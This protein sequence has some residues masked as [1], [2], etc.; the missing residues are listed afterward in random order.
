MLYAIGVLVFALGLLASIALHEV[1][2]M[3]P[4][5]R[6]GVKVTQY[7]VGFGPTLWSKRKGD[8]EYGV[9][10]I[11][12]G[13][14][15]RMIGMVPPRADGKRSR[16][17]RRMAS[18]VED[19]RNASRSEVLA[20]EDEPR[21]FYRLT[22][23]KKMIVMVGGPSMN[24]V[25]Y[26]VLTLILI[27]VVGTRHD[28]ATKTVATIET[29]VVPASASTA[30]APSSTC[31]AN[32]VK[33]PAAGVLRPGDVIEGVN[34]KTMSS[35]NDA[36]KVI[37][38]SP[39]VPVSLTILRNGVDQTVSITPVENENYAA[40][41]STIKK[42][43]YI[44]VE[45]QVHSYYQAQS[46]T[47]FP[48]AVGTQVRQGLD[49]LGNYP[50]KVHSLWQ[51]VFEGKARDP[52]GAIGVVGLGEIG[53]QVASSHEF[54]LRDKI[55]LLL[56][57]LASVNLLLFFFNLLPLLPLDGGHVAGAMVEAVKRGRAR[58]KVGTRLNEDGTVKVREPIYVDTA[59][60]LPV[61]YTIAS[62]LILM[63]LLVVYAD[64]V[65]PIN[66]G[67]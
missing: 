22:P 37:Q 33:A 60:M 16:W 11:P 46:I 59:Q 34:G 18:A 15:I 54:D 14:Y 13:G 17:P 47:A 42:V 64:I 53:G 1:G 43:G 48:G 6:F 67:G 2:H 39:G 61:V 25:I 40:G 28:D 20:P 38:A 29:C 21:Q 63:T 35:W 32:A 56:S 12:L 62:V 52:N 31:P 36:V 7:M 26:L 19:F 4:A 30:T 57:L 41:T 55:Y 50:S 51:T 23:G 5:K 49:A 3:V 24:F 66:I 27:T 10:A 45:S 44:G 65:K 9:K 58:M 8:T